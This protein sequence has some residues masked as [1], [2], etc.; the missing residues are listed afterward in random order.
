MYNAN[1]EKALFYIPR[2]AAP[3]YVPRHAAPGAFPRLLCRAR[4]AAHW[5][6]WKSDQPM[7][8]GMMCLC[9]AL[10]G[11]LFVPLLFFCYFG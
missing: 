3:P 10:L 8:A 1:T 5:I 2:H 9:G 6:A 4:A 11:L 7:S